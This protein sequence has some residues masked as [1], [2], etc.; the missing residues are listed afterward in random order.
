M[1]ELIQIRHRIKAVETI[2]KITHAMRLISMS[3]HT[4][5]KVQE[6]STTRYIQELTKLFT[7]IKT[8][9]KKWHNPILQPEHT[10]SGNH[11]VILIGS[12]KGLCGDFNST[13]F[14]FFEEFLPTFSANTHFIAVGK[15]AID[16]LEH[17]KK[18]TLTAQFRPFTSSQSTP[19]A[20]AI[21]G[22]IMFAPTPYSSVTVWSNVLKTF[23]L[24]KPE[25]TVL[26]P[27]QSP[28]GMAQ[29]SMDYHWEQEAEM[30]IDHVAQQVLKSTVSYLLFQ[31]LIAE[32]AARFVS[33]DASTRNAQT[34]LDETKLQY[35]KLRQAMI[36]KE[37]T[38]LSG[39]F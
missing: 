12:Q 3:T 37:L 22:H 31:S 30:V 23:F 25:K 10:D 4:R 36:T 16:Y 6:Q 11:L 15:K 26:I 27:F 7:A 2:K 14:Y 34:L 9:S 1:A 28:E 8:G 39:S 19:I 18:I 17:K 24:Q 32:Q 13:L 20:D 29:K 5:L 33:M 21:I 35:N 38:E